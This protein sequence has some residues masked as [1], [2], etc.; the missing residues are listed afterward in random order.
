MVRQMLRL[1]VALLAEMDSEPEVEPE[2][3]P[4]D[5]D[6]ASARLERV[7]TKVSSWREDRAEDWL[8]V[9]NPENAS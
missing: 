7:R 5:R 6:S 9:Q 8:F 1:A 4:R 2:P 3:T